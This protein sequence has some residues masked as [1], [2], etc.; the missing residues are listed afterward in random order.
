M[1]QIQFTI[2]EI[3]S[4][5][6]VTQCVYLLV[7]MLLR[8]GRLS[9]TGVP[10]AY[11]FVMCLAFLSDFA[12]R[13]LSPLV[14]YYDYIPWFLWFSGPPLSV[15]LIIQVGNLAQPPP[16]KHYWVLALVP[17]AFAVSWLVA[18]RHC[19]SGHATCAE[20]NSWMGVTGIIAGSIS[21]LAIWGWR[22][23]GIFETVAAEKGGKPRYWLMLALVFLNV[24]F[25]GAMLLAAQGVTEPWKMTMIRTVTGLGFVYLAGTSLFRIYPLGV[26]VTPPRAS[27]L[28]PA[29]KDVAAKIE[30]LLSLDKV[31]QESAYSRA[32][33]ARECGVSE[34]VLSKVINLHFQKSFPRI[35][36]ERRVADAIRLLEE[37][38]MPLQ[39][40]AADTGFNSLAGFGRVFREVTGLSPTQYRE[41]KTA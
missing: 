22:M 29:E 3:L 21:L 4:L 12:S 13:Y 5:I 23:H 32:D 11:F 19:A 24:F 30:T 39:V 10:V 16:L 9:S 7:Y 1:E 15:L 38:N 27:D 2:P 18:G 33:L 31:Y 17:L 6:G 37:T 8:A 36:N 41:K 35:M 20:M 28:S 34:A 14:P 26:R 25:L 40:I